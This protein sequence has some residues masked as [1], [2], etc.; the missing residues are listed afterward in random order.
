MKNLRTYIQ[1]FIL[2]VI[3]GIAMAQ[4]S[5]SGGSTNIPSPNAANLGTY[6]NI[7]VSYYTGTPDI[8]IPL[9]KAVEGNLETNVSLSYHTGNLVVGQ[10]ASFVGKGWSLNSG[11][12]ISR[13][14]QDKPDDSANIGY[15]HYYYQYFHSPSG[16]DNR[17][18]I[19]KYDWEPDIFTFNVDGLSGKFFF[20]RNLSNNYEAFTI[21][22]SDVKITAT[23]DTITGTNY[24]YIKKANKIVGFKLINTDGKIYHFGIADERT[25][26]ESSIL[27]SFKYKYNSAGEL[28]QDGNDVIQQKVTNSWYLLKIEDHNKNNSIEFFYED[29]LYT[30]NTLAGNTIMYKNYDRTESIIDDSRNGSGIFQGEQT[31]RNVLSPNNSINNGFST[32]R[33]YLGKYHNYRVNIVEGVRLT[34]IKTNLDVIDFKYVSHR[35][36]INKWGNNPYPETLDTIVVRSNSPAGSINSVCKQIIFDY[37][38]FQDQK[39]KYENNSIYA[40][41]R[42]TLFLKSIRER[43]CDGTIENPPYKFDYH[44]PELNA[45]NSKFFPSRLNKAIDHFG[46]YNGA[47]GSDAASVNNNKELINI[48]RTTVSFPDR[49]YIGGKVRRTQGGANRSPNETYTKYGVLEKVTYPTGGSATYEYENHRYYFDKIYDYSEE[50]LLEGCKY[51]QGNCCNTFNED[52]T[53]TFSSDKELEYAYFLL[54]LTVG[55]DADPASLQPCPGNITPKAT[56]TL[57]VIDQVSN[58]QV[59][60]KQV[61]I[62]GHNFYEEKFSFPIDEGNFTGPLQPLNVGLKS[63]VQ[64]KFEVDIN[65]GPGSFKL[66]VPRVQVE[67]NK[68]GCGLRIKKTT[69]SD[70]I[71]ETDNDMVKLYEYNVGNSNTSSGVQFVQPQYGVS[72]DHYDYLKMRKGSSSPFN[73]Y[74][75]YQKNQ[76]VTI[77]GGGIYYQKIIFSNNSLMP[78]FG[79]NGVQVGYKEVK[80]KTLPSNGVNVFK[81]KANRKREQEFSKEYP[82][83]PHQIDIENGQFEKTEVYHKN[84]NLL[85]ETTYKPWEY[86]LNSITQSEKLY[87][88]HDVF[89][90]NQ[91]AAAGGGPK[92]D[93]YMIVAVDYKINT[94][95]YQLEE[96]I[97]NAEGLT[98]STKYEYDQLNPHLAPTAVI[99]ENTDGTLKIDKFYYAV[100]EII[101]ADLAQVFTDRNLNTLPIKT[102]HHIVKNGTA[103]MIGGKKR[104]YGIFN[105]NGSK[106]HSISTLENVK[107]YPYITYSFKGNKNVSDNFTGSWVA[108]DTNLEYNA[109]GN[110]IKSRSI[111]WGVMEYFYQN[112]LITGTKY[113]NHEKSVIYYPGT[114][115]VQSKT[116]IDGTQADF[117]YDQFGRLVKTNTLNNNVIS[118]N[119]YNIL[120]ASLGTFPN[121]KTKTVYTPVI[122]SN[123]TEET[124][125]TYSDGLGRNIGSIAVNSSPNN[126]DLLTVNYYDSLGRVY[127]KS[128][129]FEGNTNG[130]FIWK[131]SNP[132]DEKYEY[133]TYEKSPLNRVLSSRISNWHPVTNEFKVND[134]SDL[135]KDWLNGGYYAPGTLSKLVNISAEGNKTITFT[136][137]FGQEILARKSNSTETKRNDTYYLYDIKGRVTTVLPPNTTPTDKD[138]IYTYT[139]DG[140]GNKISYKDPGKEEVNLLYNDIGK[141]VAKQDFQLKNQNKWHITEYDQYGRANRTGTVTSSAAPNPNNVIAQDMWTDVYYGSTGI[142]TNKVLSSTTAVLDG[143]TLTNKKLSEVIEYDSFGF[144]KK[145]TITNHLGGKTIQGKFVYDYAGNIISSRTSHQ[146]EAG[147]NQVNIFNEFE[148]D[149]H[150]RTLDKYQTINGHK[151]HLVHYE[152][153]KFGKIIT[154]Q[155][156][157]EN[158]TALQTINSSYN[159]AG[160]QTGIN[161]KPTVDDLFSIRIGYDDDLGI[162][163]GQAYKDGKIGVISW[164]H[165]GLN[166]QNYSYEY[167]YLGQLTSA[168]YSEETGNSQKGDYSC[169]YSY[170]VRGNHRSIKRRGVYKNAA[171]NFAAGVMDD[172]KYYYYGTNSNKLKKITDRS[173]PLANSTGGV[174]GV[175]GVGSGSGGAIPPSASRS[176]TPQSGPNMQFKGYH[177]QKSGSYQY[178]NN[179]NIIYDPSKNID[180]KYNYFD[181]PYE[182]KPRGKEEKIVFL[183]SATGEVLERKIVKASLTIKKTEYLGSFYYDNGVQVLNTATGKVKNLASTPVYDYHINDHLGNTRVVF[184]DRNNDD[185][186]SNNEVFQ[187][188]NY[189]PFGLSMYGEWTSLNDSTVGPDRNDH[190][191]NGMERVDDLDLAL[192]FTTYRTYDPAIGRWY[193]PDP[194]STLLPNYTPY[195][196]MVNN[197]VSYNDPDG[198]IVPALMLIG[199]AVLSGISAQKNG[200]KF[201]SGF[202]FGVFSG[203]VTM[204]IGG[205]FKETGSVGRELARAV[206]HGVAGGALSLLQGGDFMSSFASGAAS[207][208]VSAGTANWQG[209]G[210]YASSA[211]AGGVASHLSGGN[212]FSGAIQGAAVHALNFELHRA[213]LKS[214]PGG[215]IFDKDGNLVGYV[216]G[217]GQGPTQIARDLNENYSC[218]LSCETQ[219]TEIVLNNTENFGHVI[220]SGGNVLDNTNPSYNNNPDLK[221]GDVLVIVNGTMRGSGININNLGTDLVIKPVSHLHPKVRDFGL[222]LYEIMEQGGMIEKRATINEYIRLKEE[223]VPHYMRWPMRLPTGSKW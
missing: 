55:D 77:H 113:L 185:S 217:D 94:S 93:A 177:P 3:A 132:A 219:W 71:Q 36:D 78:L 213:N 142:E 84:G 146:K 12:V 17:E 127:K 147:S 115:L 88:I 48:P 45:N 119:E 29:D 145:S 27:E 58:R 49:K 135:V 152:Y 57:R 14:V 124:V 66:V 206:S 160:H 141:L 174:G 216:V 38:Y 154:T 15:M 4:P 133:T 112:N 41:T 82:I 23:F 64:Y 34:K 144:V 171:G 22:K 100:D 90:F 129:P 176:G 9:A 24:P 107:L 194:K 220:N 92:I 117:E 188:N 121:I 44:A 189:Y 43:S 76:P 136:D 173:I 223:G 148:L 46:Y 134:A 35:L 158:G 47:D 87:K 11:G 104:E 165:K 26:K 68:L 32:S 221:P 128:Q 156:G 37:E 175:G 1:L 50:I 54:N 183:Y 179:G 205:V 184:S 42:K 21:P 52:D 197:P 95:Y 74:E 130:Q 79:F 51:A 162:T 111:N 212:F 80:E 59:Y 109:N 169:Q 123:V 210:R 75:T 204:G 164:K 178:D 199:S 2:N 63:N 214:I 222:I 8:S 182:I 209:A 207:S 30:Y 10:P 138:L 180:I 103:T 67:E 13:V 60:T 163:N 53:L 201:I 155:L 181:L 102:E 192:D 5:G 65:G 166:W 28:V 120:D 81:Y 118:T 190:L 186:I 62:E 106:L 122:G 20:K 83:V 153:D 191:Y 69:L 16:N 72:V 200:G 218:M 208:L 195:N 203:T 97:T 172:L 167:D 187:I 139:Y 149:N 193:Q 110:I 7:P 150:G 19:M 143:Y 105:A 159:I 56:I 91:P 211:L 131:A 116:D 157:I 99:K 31:S 202:S 86:A 151:E 140:Q 61:N 85:S 137:G 125:I 168:E 18:D 39:L 170:D 6:A 215:P 98:T 161:A 108:V 101:D 96:I 196:S 70:G 126:K 73:K 25:A 114:R 33:P 89:N 40:G 198:D